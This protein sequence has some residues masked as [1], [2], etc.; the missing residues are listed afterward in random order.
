MNWKLSTGGYIIQIS[1]NKTEKDS[2]IR[3][4]KN[5]LIVL[6]VNKLFFDPSKLFSQ[7]L[8]AQQPTTQTQ[9]QKINQGKAKNIWETYCQ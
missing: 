9:E 1:D 7:D 3:N 5:C 6:E 8:S 4:L 2:S